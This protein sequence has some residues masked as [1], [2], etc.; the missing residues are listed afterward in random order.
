[1]EKVMAKAKKG[2]FDGKGVLCI[3]RGPTWKSQACPYQQGEV[4][5]GDWCPQVGEPQEIYETDKTTILIE[6]C[7]VE[8]FFD[9]FVDERQSEEP[10][11][12]LESGSVVPWVSPYP[13]I[14]ED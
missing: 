5:C 8:W 10:K 12:K 4:L 6:T 13:L 11:P 14:E 3:M 9:R 1:M 7:C 2:A